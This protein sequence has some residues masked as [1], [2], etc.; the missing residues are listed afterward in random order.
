MILEIKMNKKFLKNFYF[1]LD[2][3]E[4]IE[5]LELL[6]IDFQKR[7]KMAI[8]AF[9]MKEGYTIEDI[10]MPDYVEIFNVL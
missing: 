8:A 4:S 7:I 2:K 3:I 5:L 1:L 9:I 10:E 6:K